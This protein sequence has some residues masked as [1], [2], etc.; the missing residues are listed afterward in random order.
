MV[1]MEQVFLPYMLREGR[2]LYQALVE[3]QFKALP[4]SG[5]DAQ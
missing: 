2:T 5:R 3:S 4:S 1:E